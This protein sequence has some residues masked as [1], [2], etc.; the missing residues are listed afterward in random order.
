MDRFDGVRWATADLNLNSSSRL[1]PASRKGTCGRK[2][3]S[4]LH[5]FDLDILSR[6]PGQ[7]PTLQVDAGSGSPRI[8]TRDAE[9]CAFALTFL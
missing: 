9:V 2:K 7:P 5:R 4:L 6:T 8:C 3:G 1:G